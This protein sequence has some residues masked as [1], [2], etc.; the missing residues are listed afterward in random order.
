MLSG[1]I[2]GLAWLDWGWEVRKKGKERKKSKRRREGIGI[3]EVDE[4]NETEKWI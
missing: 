3:K 2:V 4:D 1:L